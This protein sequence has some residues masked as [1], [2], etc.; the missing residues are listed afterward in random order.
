M[1]KSD[2]NF[3]IFVANSRKLTYEKNSKKITSNKIDSKNIMG[4]Y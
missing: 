3:K 4:Y 2:P 1:N